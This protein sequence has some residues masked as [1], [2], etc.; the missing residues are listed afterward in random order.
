M[1]SSGLSGG[2]LALDQMTS[3]SYVP[4]ASQESLQNAQQQAAKLERVPSAPAGRN[5]PRRSSSFSLGGGQQRNVS[6][7]ADRARRASMEGRA[8]RRSGS[9]SSS[10]WQPSE[11]RTGFWNL[12]PRIGRFGGRGQPDLPDRLEVISSALP[13]ASEEKLARARVMAAKM[14]Y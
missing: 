3:T 4:P 5:V 12:I 13:A 10:D 1:P 6:L 7:E 11:S 14:N 8:V 2:G 9:A